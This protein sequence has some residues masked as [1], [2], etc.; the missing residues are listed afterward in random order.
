MA[1]PRGTDWNLD[2]PVLVLML[3]RGYH[4]RMPLTGNWVKS[5]KVEWDNGQE[6]HMEEW[7]VGSFTAAV[8]TLGA[9]VRVK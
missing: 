7:T 4:Q 1:D 9:R 6:R 8:Q 5:V 3:P 2:M